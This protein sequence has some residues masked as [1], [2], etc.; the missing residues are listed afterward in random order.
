MTS[1]VQVLRL[2]LIA[3]GLMLATNRLAAQPPTIL[4]GDCNPPP[5]CISATIAAVCQSLATN[6][7]AIANCS[8]PASTSGTAHLKT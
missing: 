5:N 2:C 7:K 3:A 6:N 1:T 4:G 8:P